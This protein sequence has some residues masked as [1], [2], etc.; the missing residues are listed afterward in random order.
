MFTT[1]ASGQS[2]VADGRRRTLLHAPIASKLHGSRLA[3]RGDA[4][5]VTGLTQLPGHQRRPGHAEPTVMPWRTSKLLQ[6]Q[7][8]QLLH[9]WAPVTVVLSGETMTKQSCLWTLARNCK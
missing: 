4:S 8:S 3:G 6:L 2:G 7:H 9:H 1:W 5:S